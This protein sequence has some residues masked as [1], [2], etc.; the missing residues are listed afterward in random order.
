MSPKKL[1]PYIAALRT[2]GPYIHNLGARRTHSDAIHLLATAIAARG[3]SLPP[4]AEHVVLLDLTVAGEQMADEQGL[5]ELL[6][7]DP[8]LHAVFHMGLQAGEARADARRQQQQ[9][10]I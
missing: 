6:D 2:G 8:V 3:G 1:R 7:N 5:R 10:G 9:P 4:G